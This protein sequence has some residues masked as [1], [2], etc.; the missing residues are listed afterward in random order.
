MIIGAEKIQIGRCSVGLCLRAS[1]FDFVGRCFEYGFYQASSKDEE[2]VPP[3]VI[4]VFDIR[5]TRSGF[6]LFADEKI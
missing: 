1:G 6:T 3:F 5:V 4:I 2:R